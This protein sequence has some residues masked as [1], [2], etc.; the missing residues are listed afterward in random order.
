MP[1]PR[2]QELLTSLIP[3][4]LVTTDDLPS[5]SSDYTFVYQSG[6]PL[7][8][9]VKVSGEQLVFQE[10]EFV[11]KGGNAEEFLRI[12]EEVLEGAQAK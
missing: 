1:Q 2:A 6:D 11:Y 7:H 3:F 4:E 12:A 9:R 5:D 10:R 8:F